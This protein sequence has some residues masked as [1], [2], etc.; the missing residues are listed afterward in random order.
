MRV[1]LALREIT[2]TNC[3][4]GGLVS[5]AWISAQEQR[6]RLFWRRIFGPGKIVSD[7]P[8]WQWRLSMGVQADIARRARWTTPLTYSAR[9]GHTR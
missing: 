5:P 9:A 3:A 1:T 2:A 8:G 7:T 6:Q 4:R